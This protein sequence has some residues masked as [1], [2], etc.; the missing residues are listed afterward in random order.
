MG[1]RLAEPRELVKADEMVAWKEHGSVAL[2]ADERAAWSDK[3]EAVLKVVSWVQKM[4]VYWA[5]PMVAS[6]DRQS[7]LLLVDSSVPAWAAST[8]HQWV[9]S[10]VA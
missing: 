8:E 4:V 9:N 1:R 3:R 5:E 10:K 2:W 7:G 6:S